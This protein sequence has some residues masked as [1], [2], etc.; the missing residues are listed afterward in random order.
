MRC[1]SSLPLDGYDVGRTTCLVGPAARYMGSGLMGF[2]FFDSN[3]V[4]VDFATQ[5]VWLKK[6]E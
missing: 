5:T 3:R 2:D 6:A 1:G 4:L